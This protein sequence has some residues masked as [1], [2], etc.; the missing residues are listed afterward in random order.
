MIENRVTKALK[1]D[2][3]THHISEYTVD[4]VKTLRINNVGKRIV[5]CVLS[6]RAIGTEC[7]EVTIARFAFSGDAAL[8]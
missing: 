6:I 7:T 3:F 5:L 8:K 2:G 4:A 1:I